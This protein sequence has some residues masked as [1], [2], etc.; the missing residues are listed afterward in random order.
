MNNQGPLDPRQ[1]QSTLNNTLTELQGLR[2]QVAPLGRDP[3]L[4]PI[5]EAINNLNEAIRAAQEGQSRFNGDMSQ[6]EKIAQQIMVPLREAE[7]ELARSLQTLV[8]K[9]KIRAA[10]EDEIPAAHQNEV[11]AYLEAVGKGK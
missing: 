8:E 3:N 4:G 11:K 5:G 10:M 1:F 9:D 6:L 2:N 7:I